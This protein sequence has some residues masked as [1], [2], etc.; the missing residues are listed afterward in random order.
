VPVS[1]ISRLGRATQGVHV[2]RVQGDDRVAAVAHIATDEPE[3][4]EEA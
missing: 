3:G 2:I 1:G 4:D